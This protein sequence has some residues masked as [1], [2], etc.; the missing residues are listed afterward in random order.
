MSDDEKYWDENRFREVGAE[1]LQ[2]ASQPHDLNRDVHILIKAAKLG[3][4]ALAGHLI[5]GAGDQEFA[6][7]VRKSIERVELALK[8]GK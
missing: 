4:E 5:V 7:R 2:E 8:N 3:V 6:S 1:R